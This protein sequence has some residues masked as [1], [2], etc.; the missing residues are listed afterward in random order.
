MDESRIR[1]IPIYLK[2]VFAFYKTLEFTEVNQ[3]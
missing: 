1:H 3:T 2:V